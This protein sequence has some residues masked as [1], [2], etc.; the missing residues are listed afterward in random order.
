MRHAAESDR[1]YLDRRAEI[2]IRIDRGQTAAQISDVLTRPGLAADEVDAL[3][4]WAWAWAHTR[5]HG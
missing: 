1:L 4:I 2:E 3:E 5:G